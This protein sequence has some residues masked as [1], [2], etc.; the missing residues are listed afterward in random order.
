MKK[1]KHLLI[2]N[3]SKEMAIFNEMIS[4]REKKG[5]DRWLRKKVSDFIIRTIMT[6]L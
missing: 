5:V 4:K 3:C 6:M 2:E 1:L